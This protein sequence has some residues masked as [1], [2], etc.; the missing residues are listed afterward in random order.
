VSTGRRSRSRLRL[1]CAG[2]VL[3][4]AALPV[5]GC[6]EVEEQSSSSYEP[7]KLEAVKG[8]DDVKRVTFTA[9]GAERVGL[10]TAPV[11]RHGRQRVLPYAAVLYD[12]QGRTYVYTSSRPLSYVRE[13]IEVDRIE[14][15]RVLVSAGPPVGTRV[16]TVGTAEV[17]GAEL[18]IAS[19]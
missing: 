8:T 14:G 17:Y 6:R 19:G 9:E 2:L 3:G 10:R 1:L 16:V 7:A 11:R 18:E 15:D 12:P 4:I 5:T 13:E